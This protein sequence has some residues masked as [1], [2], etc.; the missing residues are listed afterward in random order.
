MPKISDIVPL[1]TKAGEGRG[2]GGGRS[3]LFKDLKT[4]VLHTIGDSNYG[5]LEDS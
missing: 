4:H 5:H 2:G 1:K 3:P